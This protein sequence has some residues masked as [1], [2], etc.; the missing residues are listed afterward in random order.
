MTNH[1][2]DQCLLINFIA[3][4][5]P[6]TEAFSWQLAENQLRLM[7]S[8]I[9]ETRKAVNENN[10]EQFIDGVCDL[11]MTTFGQA[12][13]NVFPINEAFKIMADALMTRFDTHEKYAEKTRD[14]YEKLGIKT[15]LHTVEHEGTT[16]F[17]TLVDGDQ[18][19][20]Y[21]DNKWLKS[22]NTKSPLYHNI[23]AKMTKYGET[24]FKVDT[25]DSVKDICDIDNFEELAT[26]L[27]GTPAGKALADGLT[28]VYAG[29]MKDT[30]AKAIAEI[31]QQD[32]DK[33]RD[34]S[35]TLSQPITAMVGRAC[36]PKPLFH[37]EINADTADQWK[38]AWGAVSPSPTGKG[39][40]PRLTHLIK[41]LNLNE[42]AKSFPIEHLYLN[43]IASQMISRALESM[44]HHGNMI[45]A[46]E[47]LRILCAASRAQPVAHVI[48]I[49]FDEASILGIG[50][51]SAVGTEAPKRG[52]IMKAG[53]VSDLR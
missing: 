29:S 22:V 14:K 36:E 50:E 8:E 37:F 41:M 5:L 26:A 19:D 48:N 25:G 20:E 31:L 35:S 11:L 42:L 23:I 46:G 34:Q 9:R 15:K 44:L 24:P 3:G 4:K 13:R 1:L 27:N 33:V 28:R 21:P 40:D 53:G 45:K 10:I 18:G 39:E 6:K 47:R 16:Y 12:A 17:V 38:E 32:L 43:P 52:D 2:L 7:E 51:V 49:D 30:L